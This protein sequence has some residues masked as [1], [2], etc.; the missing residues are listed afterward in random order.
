MSTL[1]KN[2]GSLILVLL[3]MGL[4][5]VVTRT[6]VAG[7]QTTPREVD[8]LAAA[9]SEVPPG[10]HVDTILERPEGEFV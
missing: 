1:K 7:P 8:R 3:V 5:V 2:A 6:A 9:R 4:G 10:Q